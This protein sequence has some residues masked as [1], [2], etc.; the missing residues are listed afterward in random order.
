MLAFVLEWSCVQS[1]NSLIRVVHVVADGV[2]TSLARARVTANGASRGGRRLSGGVG[3]E[4]AVAGAAALEGV[5]ETEPVADLVGDGVAEVVVGGAAAGNGG[6]EDG[7]PIVVEVVGPAGHAGGEVAVSEVAAE[8]LEE[9][10]V[11]GAVGTLAEGL[12]HGELGTV[13]GPLGVDG[14]VGALEH[15]LDVVGGVGGV[16]DI[17]LV[18]ELG[19]LRKL[20]SYGGGW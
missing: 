11:Q 3:D 4:V 1:G 13:A 10:H 19:V 9:V 12:L 14:A 7:A 5:V 2:E 18:G 15:E 16:H 8:V 20:V 6:R 17:K